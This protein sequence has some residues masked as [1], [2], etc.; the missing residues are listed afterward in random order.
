MNSPEMSPLERNDATIPAGR[1][2]RFCRTRRRR[3][4]RRRA[5]RPCCRHRRSGRNAAL[6]WQWVKLDALEAGQRAYRFYKEKGGCGSASYLSLLS[7]L[8]EKAAIPGPRC[9]TC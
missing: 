4:H 6:P 5:D 2:D 8:Q 3:R 1:P 9:Q 7:L